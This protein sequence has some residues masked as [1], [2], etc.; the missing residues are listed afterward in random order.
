MPE[1]IL[2]ADLDAELL[3]RNRLGESQAALADAFG[4]S[5]SLVQRRI[6]RAAKL[7]QRRLA[8]ERERAR[9]D[10]GPQAG[11]PS[12]ADAHVAIDIRAELERIVREGKDTRSV[13]S[14]LKE[15]R[16]MDAPP[17]AESARENLVLP[18]YEHEHAFVYFFDGPTPKTVDTSCGFTVHRNVE[19][20]EMIVYPGPWG[21]DDEDEE[22]V[23][24]N[25]VRPHR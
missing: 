11:S 2:E 25:L 1:R 5:K 18:W 24:P 13:L 22:T 8:E 3:R 9:T 19:G 21:D 16:E 20:G 17:S 23:E 14:A 6:T 10:R 15:L 4:C 7:E 12:L